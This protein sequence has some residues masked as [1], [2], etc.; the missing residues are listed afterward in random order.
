MYEIIYKIAWIIQSVTDLKQQMIQASEDSV[1]A[2]FLHS[3]A[4]LSI[5]ILITFD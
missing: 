3:F 5:I 4:Q 1:T 2:V